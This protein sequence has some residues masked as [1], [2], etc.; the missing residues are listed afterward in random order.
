VTAPVAV[1][2]FTGTASSGISPHLVEQPPGAI[3]WCIGCTGEAM[4][5]SEL[6]RGIF[7]SPGNLVAP[8][9]LYL[10]Q[11]RERLGEQAVENIGYA[12][13]K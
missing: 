10:E 2:N 8:K 9:S 6:E 3:N 7:D 4:R 5:A 1:L 11:M 13:G 12:L